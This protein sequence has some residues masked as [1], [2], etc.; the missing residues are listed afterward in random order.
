MDEFEWRRRL[1]DLR[2][3]CEP[4]RD[5][6]VAVSARIAQAPAHIHVDRKPWLR[7]G[8]VAA[9]VLGLAAALASFFAV[10]P[11]LQSN[12]LSGHVQMQSARQD[13]GSSYSPRT[14]LDWDAPRDPSIAAAATEIDGATFTLQQALEQNPNAVFLVSLLNRSYEKR[15]RLSRLDG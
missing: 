8:A 3:A 9:V 13:A 12:R 11:A 15:M 2:T 10:R 6:W 14:A 5:L 1:R 4:A 7:T